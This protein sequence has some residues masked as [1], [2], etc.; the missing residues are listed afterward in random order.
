MR[1]LIRYDPR[2]PRCP[3]FFPMESTRK[4]VNALIPITQEVMTGIPI[5]EKI[6]LLTIMRPKLT[7]M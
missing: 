4:I 6:K 2:N 1:G 3:A 5:A 7:M